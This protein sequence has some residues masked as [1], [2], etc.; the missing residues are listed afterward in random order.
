MKVR[1][2]NES[3]RSTYGVIEMEV[4]CRSGQSCR[5]L[6]LCRFRCQHRLESVIVIIVAV[7]VDVVIWVS[8]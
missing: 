6:H 8:G 5:G 1:I 7:A 4:N 3:A 2:P